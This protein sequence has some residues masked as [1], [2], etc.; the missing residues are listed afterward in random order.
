MS[1]V[2]GAIVLD[3]AIQVGFAP[4]QV[5]GLSGCQLARI[6]TIRDAV[7]LIVFALMSRLVRAGLGWVC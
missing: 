2:G 4:F 1:I 5:L 6:H 7:L 3:L